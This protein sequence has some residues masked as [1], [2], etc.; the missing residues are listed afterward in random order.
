M[1]N[2]L[3]PTVVNILQIAQAHDVTV[4]GG[5]QYNVPSDDVPDPI[6]QGFNSPESSLTLYSQVAIAGADDFW[7]D[8]TTIKDIF[9]IIVE[10]TREVTPTCEF[11]IINSRLFDSLNQSQIKL[12]HFGQSGTCGRKYLRREDSDSHF[13]YSTHKWPVRSV[14][15]LPPYTPAKLK[16]PVLVIGNTVRTPHPRTETFRSLT[17]ASRSLGRPGHAVRGRRTHCQH[18][19]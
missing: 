4:P 9:D 13:S 6:L 15:R 8:N 17:T 7:D 16:N 18:A 12:E 10:T 1:N 19:R 2:E 3:Y 11:P 14:E 5:R